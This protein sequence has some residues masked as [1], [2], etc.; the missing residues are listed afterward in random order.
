MI[1]RNCIGYLAASLLVVL[2]GC[3]TSEGG[4]E[5][6]M[7]AL[8]N[9]IRRILDTSTGARVQAPNLGIAANVLQ[10]F[11]WK[12]M[13][14]ELKVRVEEALRQSGFPDAEVSFDQTTLTVTLPGGE[15]LSIEQALRAR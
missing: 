8:T 1:L 3:G 9:S 5:A 4:V 14:G 11:Q 13:T 2:I 10:S 7:S 15:V 12:P 6:A